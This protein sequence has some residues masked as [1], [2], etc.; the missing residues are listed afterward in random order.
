[1]RDLFY[2]LLT[3]VVFVVMLLYVRGC[4]ALGRRSGPASERDQDGARAGRFP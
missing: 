3:A 2:L 1:M 4:E